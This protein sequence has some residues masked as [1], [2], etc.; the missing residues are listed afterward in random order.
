VQGRAE[1]LHGAAGQPQAVLYLPLAHH[2]EQKFHV[3]H[4]PVETD[5]AARAA[6]RIAELI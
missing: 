2:F 3:A 6:S 4:R 5:G 1:D